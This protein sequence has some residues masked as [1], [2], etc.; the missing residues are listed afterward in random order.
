MDHVT[1]TPPD[2]D[3]YIGLQL[4]VKQDTKYPTSTWQHWH[5]SR[6]NVPMV[7]TT[8]CSLT[9][10]AASPFT[11][12][13]V[14]CLNTWLNIPHKISIIGRHESSGTKHVN[15]IYLGHLRR[16]VHDERFINRWANDRILPLINHALC[17][18]PNSELGGSSPAD[19]VRSIT[20][21][22]IYP[23]H[24]RQAIPTASSWPTSTRIIIRSITAQ[25][26]KE[27]RD[28]RQSPTPSKHVPAWRQ[29]SLESERNKAILPIFQAFTV[30]NGTLHSHKT[31]RK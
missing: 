15:G 16:L 4:I 8:H 23:L 6:Y 27:L 1:V 29:C 21:D 14:K 2:E 25:Y 20:R 22:S 17:T 30:F 31:R 13:V 3:G 28:K 10:E 9:Q 18:T 5:H 11:A 24:C 7:P 26:Q 19:S 12:T